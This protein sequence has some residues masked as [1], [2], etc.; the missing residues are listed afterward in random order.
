MFYL[1]QGL[2]DFIQSRPGIREFHSTILR[3]IVLIHSTFFRERHLPT[4]C[5]TLNIWMTWTKSRLGPRKSNNCCARLFI[6]G[7]RNQRMRS[8]RRVGSSD[9]TNCSNEISTIWGKS[10]TN[11][12]GVWS[13]GE[14][15][16]SNS[17]RTRPSRQ[18]ITHPNEESGNS[19]WSKRYREPS[20]L[21]PEQ[22]L[23]MPFIPL[24]IPPGKTDNPH[25][26]QF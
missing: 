7:T 22:M 21:K 12:N 15:T 6:S 13:K 1:Y 23:S 17:L 4:C 26:R 11:S 20:G 16:C 2:Y 19:K 5:A 10:S 24:P 18:T 3:F 8:H 9:L 25:L 14:T